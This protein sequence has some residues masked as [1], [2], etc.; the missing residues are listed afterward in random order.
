MQREKGG[1]RKKEEKIRTILAEL[2]VM[3]LTH[4]GTALWSPASPAPAASWL[5]HIYLLLYDPRL[6]RLPHIQH[7]A[8]G[9]AQLHA[10]DPRD[11]Q[12]C[13]CWGGGGLH[14]HSRLQKRFVHPSILWRCSGQ[15]GQLCP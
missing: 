8:D 4:F 12:G 3:E 7:L 6:T 10:P 13:V 14:C 15:D 2:W 11:N 5:G 9:T 1:E